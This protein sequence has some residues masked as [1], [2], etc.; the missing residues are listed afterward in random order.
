MLHG[1]IAATLTPLRGGS[2]DPDAVGPYVDFLV[3]HRL[4]GI[5]VLGT[6]GEGVLFSTEERREIA[7]AFLAAGRGR[8]QVAIH[9]GAQTTADTVALSEHA[10]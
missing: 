7:G 2:F 8:L 3:G 1:A 9:C 5:L 4:D 10:A 6:T